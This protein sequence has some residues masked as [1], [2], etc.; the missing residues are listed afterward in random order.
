M[1][2]V[3]GKSYSQFSENPESFPKKVLIEGKAYWALTPDQALKVVDLALER[4]FLLEK[5]DSLSLDLS[6]CE[7]GSAKKSEVIYLQ[8]QKIDLF[9][10]YIDQ[11]REINKKLEN[12]QAR[13][14]RRSRN[15]KNF[16]LVLFGLVGGIT[17]YFLIVK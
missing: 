9:T 12:Q 16:N 8:D 7:M 14:D 1:I 11:Q 15:F 3:S 6:R 5:N 10:G 2:A 13:T 17:G 4:N